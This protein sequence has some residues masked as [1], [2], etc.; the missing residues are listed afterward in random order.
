MSK[1]FKYTPMMEQYL[2]IK[3][4]HKNDI[5]MF[6]MGDFFEIFFEDA[7]IAAKELNIALTGRD[8][9]MAERAPMCGVPAHAAD[10]YIAKLVA[11]GH[12][13]ALCEQVEDPKQAKGLV[14]REVVRVYTP[15]TMTDGDYLDANKHNYI[16]A[17]HSDKLQLGLA[18]ADITTGLFMATSMPAGE[19]Q[20]LLDE[21]VRLAPAELLL[22]EGFSLTRVVESVVGVKATPVPV[23]TFLPKNAYKCLTSHFGTLNLEGFGL[24][25]GA[26]EVSAAGALLS[27][28]M[29]TQRKSISQITSLRRYSQQSHMMLDGA[30]RRNLELTS[31]AR[32]R[33]KKGSL[34]WVLDR[35][36]TS[37]GA[38]LLREWVEC[39]LAIREAICKRL[40]AVAEWVQMPIERAELREHLNSIHDLERVVSR[41]MTRSASARD[42]VTLRTS[43]ETLPYVEA[44]LKN[45]DALANAEIRNTYDD[46]SDIYAAINSAIIDTPPVSVKEGGMIKQGYNSELDKLLHIKNNAQGYLAELEAREKQE[47]GI[48]NLKVRYNRVFGYYIEVTASHLSKV[49]ERY[50]RKQTLANCERF[51]T[52][53]LKSLEETILGAEEKIFSLEFELFDTLRRSIVEQVARIQFTAHALSTLDALQSLADV[54]DRNRYV[55]P[56][57]NEGTRIFI[58]EGRH[59]VVESLIGHTF[60]PNDTEMDSASATGRLAVITG[61]N[62]AGKST[63]MRQVALIVLMAQIGSF[64]PASAAEIGIVDRIFTRVGASDDLATGQSTFM[65]EM[66]EVANI[67]NNATPNSLVL[68]DEIGRGTSTFDGLSIAWA[69][70]EY[71][72][73]TRKIGAKTLFAT[74][75]HEL[76]QLEGKIDGVANYCFTAK[77]EGKDI[78]FLR[79]LIHGAAGQSYGVHVAKLAGLPSAVLKRATGLLNALNTTDI[80]RNVSADLSTIS[81]IATIESPESEAGRKLVEALSALEIEKMTPIEALLA[82]EKLKEFVSML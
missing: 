14:A 13:V 2:S 45:V 26:A 53:E 33:T 16:V 20:K 27:Y 35:T 76:S 12:R 28:L 34:L 64:V 68:L 42:L 56:E 49:P 80:T 63:Y 15:G 11:K 82:L 81:E 44:L 24:R 78:V 10:G 4:Q 59:P 38:R 69:V 71:I 46:L 55:K 51:F 73:D 5:L 62:M 39:P 36:K 54:A 58:K 79:K 67:L 8:C 43:L 29:E 25:E 77:E 18:V 48:V 32:E 17:I 75:Y 52:E 22:P 41:L 1:P 60:I 21:A 19:E 40:D 6:R 37:M 30:S 57:I 74:H 66:T 72:A 61:P 9:G 70:L 65:V 31:S 47:T 3:A 50:I 23:W 7:K